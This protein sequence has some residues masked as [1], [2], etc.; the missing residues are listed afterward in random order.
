MAARRRHSISGRAALFP[1]NA[2]SASE[3]L[4]YMTIVSLMIVGIALVVDARSPSE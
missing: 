2:M 1:R 3:I 4:I